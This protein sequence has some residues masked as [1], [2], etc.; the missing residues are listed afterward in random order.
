MSADKVNDRLEY[1]RR[2]HAEMLDSFDEE[3]EMEIDDDRMNE[4]VAEAMTP[5]EEISDL[6]RSFYFKELFR[7][8]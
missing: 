2:V 3:L 1:E 4:L 8:L 6:G 5:G 7:R